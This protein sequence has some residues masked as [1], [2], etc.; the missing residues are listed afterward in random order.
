MLPTAGDFDLKPSDTET[1]DVSI[2]FRSFCPREILRPRLVAHSSRFWLEWGLFASAVDSI[3]EQHVPL[4]VSFSLRRER[5]QATLTS[6]RG[7]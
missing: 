4:I 6:C 3:L 2:V 7:A 5:Q 1:R